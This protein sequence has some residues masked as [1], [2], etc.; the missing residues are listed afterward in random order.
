M[1]VQI[2]SFIL[3]NASWFGIWGWPILVFLLKIVLVIIGALLLGL[4]LPS[5][6]LL[7]FTDVLPGSYALFFTDISAMYKCLTS[8]FYVWNRTSWIIVHLWT[9]GDITPLIPL[10][11]SWSHRG[12]VSYPRVF[13][14]FDLTRNTRGKSYSS[15][16]R[17]QRRPAYT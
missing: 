7:V 5:H 14:V 16:L 10:E 6:V 9:L 11:R 2:F 8:Y 3:R 17:S 12:R 13:L 1:V 15:E 4:R